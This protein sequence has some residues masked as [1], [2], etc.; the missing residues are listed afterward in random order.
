MT[1]LRQAA[2]ENNKCSNVATFSGAHA[3]APLRGAENLNP[4]VG[5]SIARPRAADLYSVITWYTIA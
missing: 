3:G 2:G 1:F 5:A 4:I